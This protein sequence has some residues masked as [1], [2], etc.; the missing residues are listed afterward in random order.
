VPGETTATGWYTEH[1]N[2]S[3]Q[4]SSFNDEAKTASPDA[5]TEIAVAQAVETADLPAIL[6]RSL[7][8]P[9]FELVTT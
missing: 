2:G 7:Q 6:A 5:Q 8:P 3:A 9:F 4:S 1:A